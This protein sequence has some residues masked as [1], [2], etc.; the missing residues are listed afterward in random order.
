M[1]NNPPVKNIHP[2]PQF[3][4]VGQPNSGKSTIF[5]SVAGYRSIATN[6]PGATV[7]YI[8]S[9]VSVNNYTCNLVDLP[10]LYSLTS[11]DKATEES[12][13]YLLRER[14]DVIINVV[15]ASILSRSLELTLQLLELDI[16]MVLCLNMIDEAERKGIHI[17]VKK[18]EKLL[19]IP[20]VTTVGSKGEGLN[21]LFESA[22]ETHKYHRKGAPLPLSRHVENKIQQL[23]Q[24]ISA[25]GSGDIQNHPRLYAIKLLENDPYFQRHAQSLDGTLTKKVEHYQQEL[26][27]EHGRSSDE[28]ISSE[29][30]SLAMTLFEKSAT[31]SSRE[32][33]WYDRV[34]DFIMHP[35]WGLLV[36]IGV[37]AV[38]FNIVF[39]F[40]AWVE[41]P[42]LNFLEN[43]IQTLLDP[44]GRDSL[45]FQSLHG[46]LQGMAGGIAI[47][48]PYLLPFMIGMALIEDI[49]YLPRIAFLMDSIMHKIGLHG[50]AIVP[51]LLG[52]GCSVP[53]VMATRILPTARDRFIATVVAILVPCSARMTVI[54]GLVGYYLGGFAVLGIYFL[55][56]IVI[57]IT[58]TILN[59]MLPADSPGMIMEI[60]SYHRP[61]LRVILAKTWL[62]LRDFIVVAWPLLVVG[63]LVLNIAQ[64]YEL[65]VAINSLLSP[66][67]YL[68]DLPKEVGT[69]L[70]FG[71][72]RKELSMLML[73][74]ALETTNVTAVMSSV[75]IIVFTLF[76][77]FYIPCLA[78]LGVMGKEV[79]W[80][81][82]LLATVITLILATGIALLGRG[83]GLL[84]T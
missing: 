69:T 2:H 72:L 63:S 78:T 56:I 39:Q 16:P 7:E 8:K 23:K 25:I 61:V 60:P 28:V 49:G 51:A 33:R 44:F 11:F 59:R 74:Q 79:G 42:L 26:S 58:G 54:M 3:V 32:Y 80:R 21:E 50:T 38:F 19:G 65:D 53:A 64:W 71:I 40:G 68:L 15:D 82:T 45:L 14:T 31:V 22:F 37:L 9:H 52:Y 30:H 24:D 84:V 47:V 41:E 77:V 29:R 20:V 67:T 55:N 48:L 12:K 27:K 18:L 13:K 66:L 73:F 6:F 81:R 57:A 36:M 70:I 62:R 34:D 5:N 10:G 75:Q 46:A 4:L 35:V 76:V 1:K 17:D 83:V 43:G